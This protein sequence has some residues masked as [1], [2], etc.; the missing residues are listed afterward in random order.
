MKWMDLA[1]NR[2]YGSLLQTFYTVFFNTFPHMFS[3]IKI[4]AHGEPFKSTPLFFIRHSWML[5][6][7]CSGILSPWRTHDQQLSLSLLTPD[8]LFPLQNVMVL[9]IYVLNFD[10]DSVPPMLL[11]MQQSSPRKKKWPPPCFIV[12]TVLL[13][14]KVSSKETLWQ[15]NMNLT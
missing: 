7:A 1:T 4:R 9:G 10:L 14:L 6:A 11:Y 5:L 3:R 8:S 15:D 13:C 12:S 2:W